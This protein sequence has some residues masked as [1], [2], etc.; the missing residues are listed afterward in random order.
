MVE[1]HR[2]S[3]LTL[4]VNTLAVFYKR[5]A[6]CK[7]VLGSFLPLFSFHSS[8]G[9]NPGINILPGRWR[10]LVSWKGLVCCSTESCLSNTFPSFY[11]KLSWHFLRITEFS[12]PITIT[13]GMYQQSFLLQRFAKYSPWIKVEP[14]ISK[15]SIKTNFLLELASLRI[16]APN[17]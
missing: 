12:A 16:Y 4:T 5:I 2:N 13:R 1:D 7:D 10:A 8:L 9:K 17:L 6:V 14:L 3:G 15:F 11:F